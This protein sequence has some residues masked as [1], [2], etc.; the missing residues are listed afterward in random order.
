MLLMAVGIIILLITVFKKKPAAVDHTNTVA[1]LK[2]Q[3]LFLENQNAALKN[4]HEYQRSLDSTLIKKYEAK[5]REDYNTIQQLKKNR[6]E[7]INVIDT[8]GDAE[9]RR[10]LAEG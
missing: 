5:I 8:A 10:I 1:I 6:D 2:E 4:K 7:K 9:L 3:I